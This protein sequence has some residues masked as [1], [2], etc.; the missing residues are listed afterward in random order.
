MT[1]Y[2]RR[3]KGLELIWR[4]ARKRHFQTDLIFIFLRLSLT[5]NALI[6]GASLTI[7]NVIRDRLLGDLDYSFLRSPPHFQE[8]EVQTKTMSGDLFK[9]IVFVLGIFMKVF[10]RRRR[11]PSS[12]GW[13]KNQVFRGLE[14][15]PRRVCLLC[16]KNDNHFCSSIEAWSNNNC[17]ISCLYIKYSVADAVY[18]FGTRLFSSL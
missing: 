4:R 15:W 1:F 16:D 2:C 17:E 14:L 18:S 12:E 10:T 11:D 9:I 5:T 3:E 13:N 7:E 8:L 6:K